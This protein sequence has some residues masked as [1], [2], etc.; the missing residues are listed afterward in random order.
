GA[1][2]KLP[3]P[4]FAHAED[5]EP[6]ATADAGVDAAV[7]CPGLL[8]ERRGRRRKAGLLLAVGPPRE[9]HVLD[10]ALEGVGV[11]ED[12]L[13]EI[14]GAGVAE[15]RQLPVQ[16]VRGVG[17]QVAGGDAVG[18]EARHGAAGEGHPGGG[19]LRGLVVGGGGGVGDRVAVGVEEAV[20]GGVDGGG[21]GE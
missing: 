12:D 7:E 10:A 20:G 21:G 6:A 1:G 4:L 8:G 3:T 9:G 14:V 18:G 17:G 19:D 11:G 15:A 5:V 13:V 2:E 16:G